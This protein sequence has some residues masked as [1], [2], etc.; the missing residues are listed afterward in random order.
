MWRRGTRNQSVRTP[1]VRTCEMKIKVVPD[2]QCCLLFCGSVERV[3][4]LIRFD[5]AHPRAIP[6]F[7]FGVAGEG[8]RRSC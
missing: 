2:P 5:H 3:P 7:E 1:L 8:S 6:S 4:S